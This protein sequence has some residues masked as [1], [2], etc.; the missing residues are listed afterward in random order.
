MEKDPQQPLPADTGQPPSLPPASAV[1]FIAYHQIIITMSW[2]N[3]ILNRLNALLALVLLLCSTS[4]LRSPGR[5]VEE[6]FTSWL[7]FH[8]KRYA[9]IE[10]HRYRLQVFQKNARHV[11]LHNEAY[12]QGHTLYAMTLDSP[13]SDLTDE[14]FVA[15]Y[16]MESQGCSATTHT[17]SGR[18]RPLSEDSN[19]AELC[20]HCHPSVD[21]RTQGILTPVKNQLHC[22][23]CWT[24][25][26][27]GC[28]EAHLCL[29]AGKDCTQWTGLAEQQLVDC[30][31]AFNNHGCAGGLPSQA[32]EYIKYSGG[33]A[34]EKDYPYTSLGNS[35][36][37]IQ[38]HST[39]W[40]GQVAEVFN[41]T[42]RDEADLV[43]A[44]KTIG[45]VSIAYQVSPDFRFYEH[46]IYDSYNATT[47]QIMCHDGNHDVNHA[48]V[49]VGLGT[50]VQ[51]VNG[52][53]TLTDYYIVRNS[54]GT[55]WGME[56]H[57]WIKRGENLCGLS[58][59]ASFP[60]VPVKGG[61]MERGETATLLRG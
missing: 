40:R 26:T 10:E 53:Q 44:V 39:K 8:G 1:S 14:E 36:C 34:T 52:T 15:T 20:P 11:A 58:D 30:A 23:S 27:S 32:F 42:S 35:T 24:F 54:W 51:D 59:C 25:S 17:S 9:T 7:L 50:S 60:I 4:A 55:L 21:W 19:E 2:L 49:A 33:M 38:A 16:L 18:L 47:G 56:G 46:G 41:I 29:A 28:L 31:Q 37:A 5:S 13:F 22:G 45:P 57:F 6:Q 61:T 48:V 12:E 43:H 3:M